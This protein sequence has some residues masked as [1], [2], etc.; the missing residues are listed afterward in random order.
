MTLSLDDKLLFVMVLKAYFVL[1]LFCVM[2]ESYGL[3]AK[4][5]W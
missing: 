5:Y 2:S 1:K 3:Q 4:F